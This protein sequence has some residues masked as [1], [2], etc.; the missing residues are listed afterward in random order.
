L[1]FDDDWLE[2]GHSVTFVEHSPQKMGVVLEADKPWENLGIWPWNT[3]IY[4]DGVFK[5]WYDAMTHCTPAKPGL[6][7]TAHL[8]YAT[9]RDGIHWEKR[10]LGL[11]PFEGNTDNNILAQISWLYG[12]VFKDPTGPDDR[13][14]KI[15]YPG[16]GIAW[17]ADGL[18]WRQ[19][20]KWRVMRHATDSGDVMFWDDRLSKYVGYFRYNN[21]SPETKSVPRQV[22]RSET[23][24]IEDWPQ[25][26]VNFRND[27]RHDPP[28]TDFYNNGV[29][30]YPWAYHAYFMRPSA[31][32]HPSDMLEIHLATSRDG[33]TWR[34]PGASR[35]W[36]GVGPAG[37]FDSHQLYIASGIV[38]VGDELWVYYTGFQGGHGNVLVKESHHV[39]KVGRAVLRLD[40]F[41]SARGGTPSGTLTTKPLRVA[42]RSLI[43]NYDAG[44]TGEVRAEL[45]DETDR[46]IPGFTLAECRP[47]FGNQVHGVVTWAKQSDVSEPAAKPLRLH[48]VIRNADVYAFEFRKPS[49]AALGRRVSAL[50]AEVF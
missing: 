23:A 25:A 28:S 3:V 22:W 18:R 49:S 19:P 50:T 37:S 4:D 38:R 26:V 36:I 43:L 41:V 7:F 32:Y 12:S 16:I 48:L 20:A 14:Y 29:I 31:F 17:S 42:G 35:A 44:A 30:K 9:S 40:G 34:R 1:L 21:F 13:R 6:T 45:R 47:L 15:T 8:A 39:G 2:P 24:N 5:M 11:F 46:P 27:P 33:I 10:N